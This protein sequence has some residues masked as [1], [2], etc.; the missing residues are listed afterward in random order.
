MAGTPSGHLQV[1]LMS[2]AVADS[3]LTLVCAVA[4]QVLPHLNNLPG[5]RRWGWGT[6]LAAAVAAVPAWAHGGNTAACRPGGSPD[7]SAVPRR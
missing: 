5:C 1:H 7:T 6:P 3:Q 4:L 2:V